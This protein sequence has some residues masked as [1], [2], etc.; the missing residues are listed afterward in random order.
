MKILFILDLYKPHIWWAEILFENITKRIVQA[1]HQVKILTSRYNKNLPTYEKSKDGIEIYRVWSSRYDFIF[2]C[3]KKWIQ[4]AGQSDIIHWTT[5][6]SAIPTSLI[7]TISNK[8]TILTVH[9]IFG[10]LRYKF[11]WRKWFFSYIFECLIFKFHYNKIICVSNY[12]KNCLRIHFWIND[13]KLITIYNGIDYNQWNPKNFSSKNINAIREKYHLKQNYIW[14][15]FGRS[16]I[17]KWLIYFVKA[18]PEIIKI[19]PN[20]KAILNVSESSD[21]NTDNIKKFINE[22]WLKNYII[23]IEWVPYK[24][25]W[26][27]ILA[28]N[29]TVV[30]S[31]TEWFW[32]AAAETCAIWWQLICSDVAALTEVVYGKINF[33]EPGNPHDIT[34]KMINFYNWKYQTITKKNFSWEDN[35]NQTIDCYKKVLWIT[36]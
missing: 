36:E 9:E 35:I 2:S 20:F 32:F 10:K 18:I 3:I 21:N 1:W 17:S 24:E 23:R 14:L 11:L 26:N 33:V 30:P 31:L 15:F 7:W 8:K 28:S 27:Y 12:T 4:L 29:V 19:I 22:N 13:S 34:Q 6:I 5:F 16:W 25:L